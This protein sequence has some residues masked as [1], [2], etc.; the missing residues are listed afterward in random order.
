MTNRKMIDAGTAERLLATW[1]A[2]HEGEL[3]VAPQVREVADEL[4][5]APLTMVG[6][7]DTSR[8][9]ERALSFGRTSGMALDPCPWLK[10]SP[11]FF[12]CSRSSL[13]P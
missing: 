7:V 2:L 13:P 11:S 8:L 12:G 9:S 10:L 5:A 4:M 3:K 1:R 6:L